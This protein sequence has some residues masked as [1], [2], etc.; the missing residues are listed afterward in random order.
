VN[1]QD[2]K[3]ILPFKMIIESDMEKMRHD[4]FYDKEPETIN[5]IKHFPDNNVFMDIGA[6]VGIYS[7]YNA[8]LH[9]ESFTV[10]C[11]PSLGNYLHLASNIAMNGFMNVMSVNVAFSNQNA[12]LPLY[13]PNIAVG[14]SG[15]QL[16]AP[17]DSKGK[18]FNIMGAQDTMA[19]QLRTFLDMFTH[20]GKLIKPTHIK[21]DVDG[22]EGQILDGMADYPELQSMLIEFNSKESEK[23]Y[24]DILS[25]WGF[26]TDN[27][28]NKFT[29][30]ST[31]RRQAEGDN[32]SVNI[33]F[34]RKQHEQE[35]KDA[36]T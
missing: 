15:G 35:D 6:N 19:F 26:T 27:D 12:F 32:E 30:H 1:N 20:L 34:T 8:K 2:L 18:Q 10:A 3:T 31:T 23:H 36:T 9:P 5:W 29:P 4:T 16:N 14:S 17:Q 13:L 33:I 25:S 7:L 28:F 21:I 24:L 22:H 11:E